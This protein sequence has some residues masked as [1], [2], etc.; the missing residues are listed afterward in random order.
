M[1]PI[2]TG[3][4][5]EQLELRDVSKRLQQID[6]DVVVG[7]VGGAC[8]EKLKVALMRHWQEEAEAETSSWCK[9]VYRKFWVSMLKIED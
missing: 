5:E 9:S 7:V 8:L 2:W 4:R 6:F 3:P 1:N